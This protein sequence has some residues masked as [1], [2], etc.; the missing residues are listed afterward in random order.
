MPRKRVAKCKAS[1]RATSRQAP[2]NADADAEDGK[3]TEG[4]PDAH[5]N[6]DVYPCNVRGILLSDLIEEEAAARCAL[7]SHHASIMLQAPNQVE[8]AANPGQTGRGY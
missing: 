7:S 4:E 2:S 3:L 1:K 6:I 5:D 8:K